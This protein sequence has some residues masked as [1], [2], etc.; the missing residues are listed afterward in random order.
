VAVVRLDDGGRAA[1]LVS[2]AHDAEQPAAARRQEQRVKQRAL[3]LDAPRVEV[4]RLRLK[5]LQ[6]PTTVAHCQHAAAAA[7]AGQAV[8]HAALVAGQ[9]VVVGAA[10]AP[11]NPRPRRRALPK[12][13][14]ERFVPVHATAAGASDDGRV[15]AGDRVPR[16]VLRRIAREAA[17]RALRPEPDDPAFVDARANLLV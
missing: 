5:D 16:R 15:A 3:E 6:Q 10:I 14:L 11:V 12:H 1:H 7:L 17:A 4:R 9:A 8:L 2:G 13:V